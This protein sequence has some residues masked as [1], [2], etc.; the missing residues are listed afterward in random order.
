MQESI[1]EKKRAEKNSDSKEVFIEKG[2]IEYGKNSYRMA[3]KVLRKCNF[4]VEDKKVLI[5]PNLVM[6]DNSESGITADVSLCRAI[7][8]RIDNC[9][10]IIG[11]DSD[12]FEENGYV[13]LAREYNAEIV[14]FDHMPKNLIEKRK[15]PYPIRFKTIPMAKQVL[16]ADYII[17]LG[18]LK[19]HS[20]C[21][22]TLT[23]KN[24][25]GCVPTRFYRVIIHPYIRRALLDVLQVAYPDF[26]LVDG[27]IGNQRD[28]VNSFSIPHGV[29]FG[30]HNCLAVDFIGCKLMG[31]NPDDIE[32]L[33]LAKEFYNFNE[34]KI[35]VNADI[36]KLKKNYNNS[37]TFEVMKRYV[38]EILMSQA[39]RFINKF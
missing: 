38:T 30:G 13:K 16:D 14:S 21:Q 22:V 25:F 8:D 7:L 35:K 27:I 4:K 28:E 1:L 36:D 9:R 5:K 11:N 17:S 31:L 29:I 32:F 18:K 37:R 19:I 26:G 10:V 6:P 24:M 2:R 33:R 3:S 20:V 15:V 34:S 23:L 39:F 12:H